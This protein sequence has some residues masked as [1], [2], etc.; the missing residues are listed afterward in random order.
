MAYRYRVLNQA[1]SFLTFLLITSFCIAPCCCCALDYD[2]ARQE[3]QEQAAELIGLHFLK[4]SLVLSCALRGLIFRKA[5]CLLR[6]E[7]RDRLVEVNR[8]IFL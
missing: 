8:L 4:P 1:T 2:S 5:N 7:Y 3:D 6:R